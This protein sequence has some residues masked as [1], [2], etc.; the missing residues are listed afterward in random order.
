MVVRVAEALSLCAHRALVIG[1]ATSHFIWRFMSGVFP[2]L[3]RLAFEL[4]CR[5][6]GDIALNAGLVIRSMS[7]E[8]EKR[9]TPVGR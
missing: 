6:T 4:L 5:R 7:L 8:R 3:I 1:K 2:V 9:L